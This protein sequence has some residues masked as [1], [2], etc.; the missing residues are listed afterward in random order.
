MSSKILYDTRTLEILWS[1][2]K[3][4]GLG[5]SS[6]DSLCCSAHIPD[7]ERQYMDTVIVDDEDMLTFDAQEKLKIVLE[8]EQSKSRM[9]NSNIQK[10]KVKVM[11]KS[12]EELNLVRKQKFSLQEQN[13]KEQKIKDE[14]LL[15]LLKDDK[16]KIQQLKEEYKQLNIK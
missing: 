2:K 5:F 12:E 7:A 3:P 6:L 8:E 10:P 14:L 16:D 1:Q 13:F 15:A 4:C 11:R 9:L